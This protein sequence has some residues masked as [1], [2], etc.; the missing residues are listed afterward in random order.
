MDRVGGWPG[1]AKRNAD[2]VMDSSGSLRRIAQVGA[3]GV[4]LYPGGAGT[5]RLMR[6]QQYVDWVRQQRQRVP[7][8]TSGDVITAAGVSA[9]IDMAPHLVEGAPGPGIMRPRTR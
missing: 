1:L 3:V 9:G 8:M 2:R 7:L 5:R 4:L 6:D